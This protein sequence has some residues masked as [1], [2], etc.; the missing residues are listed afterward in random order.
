[1]F[2]WKRNNLVTTLLNSQDSGPLTNRG[3]SDPKFSKELTKSSETLQYY[4]L[5]AS[6]TF[7]GAR[8]VQDNNHY[9][10]KLL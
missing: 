9:N 2:D 7:I 1:M 5:M 10:D 8:I 3:F 4:K 6:K